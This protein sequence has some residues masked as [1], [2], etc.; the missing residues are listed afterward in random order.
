MPELLEAVCFEEWVS[1][2]E[3]PRVPILLSNV[4][5]SPAALRKVPPYGMPQRGSPTRFQVRRAIPSS[6]S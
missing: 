5:V 2:E 4:Q 3:G 1:G 6:F